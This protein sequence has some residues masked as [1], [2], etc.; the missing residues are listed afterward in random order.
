MLNEEEYTA[1]YQHIYAALGGQDT[2]PA[3][4]TRYQQRLEES[5]SEV[6]IALF[7][8]VFQKVCKTCQKNGN[9]LK[10]TVGYLRKHHPR[11][12][13]KTLEVIIDLGGHCDCEVLMNAGIDEYLQHKGEPLNGPD[14]LGEWAWLQMVNNRI[15]AVPARVS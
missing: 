15:A 2:L 5:G 12:Y 10:Y 4:F 6:D 3:S 7:A 8:A 14:T 9:R 1:L 13:R 11:D